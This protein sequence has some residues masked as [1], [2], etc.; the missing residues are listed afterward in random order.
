MRTIRR[1]LSKLKSCWRRDRETSATVEVWSPKPPRHAPTC[2]V[3][4]FPH[5]DRSGIFSRSHGGSRMPAGQHLPTTGTK[6]IRSSTT[7]S[8]TTTATPQMRLLPRTTRWERFTRRGTAGRRR[9]PPE[10]QKMQARYLRTRHLG[11][12]HQPAH[13]RATLRPWASR[14]ARSAP[15][16]PLGSRPTVVKT[17][18]SCKMR[19]T[20]C[21]PRPRKEKT[22]RMEITTPE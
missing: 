11:P 5:M 12:G 18:L 1:K 4:C 20:R 8:K 13:K 16:G 15:N 2:P 3:R 19:R 6:T 7:H 21:L 17:C 14:K 22:R 10:Q 9:P